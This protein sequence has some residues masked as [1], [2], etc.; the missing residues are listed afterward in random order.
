M[1]QVL[2]KAEEHMNKTVS[3]LQEDYAAV[4]AGRA[5]PAILDKVMVDY[6]GAPTAINQL[7][8]V[9]VSEARV[10]TIQPWDGSVLKAIEKAIQ[11]SDIGINP[12]N[13]GKV[14]RLTFP[15][16]TEERRKE[17]A[18]EIS[19][20]AEES[21]IAVRN[22]RRDAMDKLKT[23]KKNSELTEDDLN[24]AEKKTQELT[25]R[26]CKEIDAIQTKKNKEI[27]EI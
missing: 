16:L 17:L 12:Q 21:K 22:I 25:D 4:R 7:A 6:Y 20:M 15:Q 24:K 18:K 9:S 3:V 11:T 2:A 27:M 10:L 14:I 19:K 26:F 23:M 13:D 5:N 8:A 1:K